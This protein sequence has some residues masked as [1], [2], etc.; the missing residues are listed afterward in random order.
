MA[1]KPKTAGVLNFPLQISDIIHIH[2]KNPGA[3]LAFHMIMLVPLVIKTIRSV[4][5]RNF[6]DFSRFG[7]TVQI[8]I[9]RRP[10]DRGMLLHNRV[11]NFIRGGM[12]FQLVHCL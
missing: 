8:P 7:Q 4:R 3:F 2:I 5:D 12:S 1:G 6:A 11:I 9:H 10:A